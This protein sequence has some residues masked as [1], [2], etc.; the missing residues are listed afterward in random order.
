MLMFMFVLRVD[1]GKFH[2][3]V[4]FYRVCN[5]C[6]CPSLKCLRHSSIEVYGD[7]VLV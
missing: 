1:V 4:I 3:F 6:Q 5:V 7:S 2:D